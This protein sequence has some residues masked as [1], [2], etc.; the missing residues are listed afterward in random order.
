MLRNLVTSFFEHEQ[1][2]T[3]D[4]KA[5]ELRRIAEKMI[6]FAKRGDLHARRQVLKVLRSKKVTKKLFEEIAQRFKDRQ[7]GYTRIVKL[8]HR[9]GDNAP[10]SLIEL[11]EKKTK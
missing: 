6:T 8:G 7:G 4:A 3:T 9:A 1:I 10:I 11:V 2:T 5:K